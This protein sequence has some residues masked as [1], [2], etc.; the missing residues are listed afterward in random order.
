M[1]KNRWLILS[2][3]AITLAGILA[4]MGI[5]IAAA[6]SAY[7]GL[8]FMFDH[9]RIWAVKCVTDYLER[10]AEWN[11]RTEQE[12]TDFKERVA[13]KRSARIGDWTRVNDPD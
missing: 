5:W 10:K 7:W 2:F 9:Y 11:E 1:H 3:V 12:L 13:K 4:Q 6:M 8:M